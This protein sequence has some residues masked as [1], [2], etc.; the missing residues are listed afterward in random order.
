MPFVFCRGEE[1]EY[2]LHRGKLYFPHHT[3]EELEI[4]IALAE[5]AGERP[6]GC[7]GVLWKFRNLERLHFWPPLKSPDSLLAGP[8]QKRHWRR[9]DRMHLRVLERIHRMERRRRMSLKLLRRLF[10]EV[11]RDP[12]EL[13]IEDSGLY[14]RRKEGIAPLIRLPAEDFLSAYV[15][16]DGGIVASPY[17]TYI[18]VMISRDGAF[19]IGPEGW[20]K[21]QLARD[22]SGWTIKGVYRY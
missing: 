12:E 10:A 8:L 1:H 17:G 4:E 18:I 20:R 3:I 21:V 6:G 16:T 19:G 2:G 15:E 7:A 11:G 14:W 13:G 22:G 9:S 5:L